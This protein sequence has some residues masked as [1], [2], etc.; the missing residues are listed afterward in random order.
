[1]NTLKRLII[2]FSLFA[3]SCHVVPLQMVRVTQTEAFTQTFDALRLN[4]PVVASNDRPA[5][6]E[7]NR[8][9]DD[10][11]TRMLGAKNFQQVKDRYGLGGVRDELLQGMITS[12]G[13]LTFTIYINPRDH[14]KFVLEGSGRFFIVREATKEIM[15]SGDFSIPI[16]DHA[17]DELVKGKIPITVYLFTSNIGRG[18]TYFHKAPLIYNVGVE[19]LKNTPDA[20]VLKRGKYAHEVHLIDEG[21]PGMEYAVKLGNFHVEDDPNQAKIIDLRGLKLVRNDYQ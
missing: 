9:I 6:T 21:N 4:A 15:L 16:Q 3:F 2:A 1:M 19:Q 12:Q 8:L 20:Y 7:Q 11:F 18:S 17:L 14:T 10:T 13:H 5:F